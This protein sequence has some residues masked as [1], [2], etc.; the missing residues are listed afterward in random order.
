MHTSDYVQVSRTPGTTHG[1]RHAVML[2][3]SFSQNLAHYDDY[4]AFVDLYGQTAEPDR[5]IEVRRLGV[6]AADDEREHDNAQYPHPFFRH[7]GCT[8]S[9]RVY[10]SGCLTAQPIARFTLGKKKENALL[11]VQP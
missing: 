5:L 1:A 7:C 6:R 10:R 3:H 4:A 8:P 9:S 2:V 11:F